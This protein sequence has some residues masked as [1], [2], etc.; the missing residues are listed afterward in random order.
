[1]NIVP[2]NYT[3]RLYDINH[4]LAKKLNTQPSSPINKYKYE[5]LNKEYVRFKI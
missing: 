1:M 5:R 2:E 4:D 3:K